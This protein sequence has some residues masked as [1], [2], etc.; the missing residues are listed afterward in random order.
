MS[1]TEIR[2]A[3]F[4]RCSRSALLAGTALRAAALVVLATPAVAQL[5]PAAHPTGG[6]V[7]GG[8]AGISQAGNTTL[9]KQASQAASINWQNFNVGSQA[10]VAFQQPNSGAIALNRVVGPDP[11]EIAGHITANGQVV[12]VNQSGVIFDQ[13]S[14]VDTAGLVVSAS[15]IIDKNFMAGHMVFDQA[16]HP[17]ARVVNN[18]TITIRQAGLAALVAP[19][20]SNAGLIQAKLGRVILAG[21]STYTLDL[22]GD[23]LLAINVTDQVTS[24]SLGGRIVPALVTNMGTIL[25]DGGTVMLTAQAAD[26]LIRT[27]VSAGG[28]IAAQS[29]GTARG[30]ILAQGIG[31]SVEID[32][33]V[34]ASGLAAGT[35]GGQIE[36]NS[37]GAVNIGGGSAIDASGNAGGGLIAIGATAAR[38]A[39]G[40]HVHG[41]LTAS[42]VSVAKGARLAADATHLGDGGRITLLSTGLTSAGGA[43]SVLGGAF[44]G[45]GGAAE[46]SGAAVGLAGLVDARA[47]RGRTG[48]L[49]IDP[50]S[51]LIADASPTPPNLGGNTF[52]SVA[53]LTT[54]LA[55]ANVTMTATGDIDFLYNHGTTNHLVAGTNAL[56]LTA[57]QGVNIDNG[58]QITG[59]GAVTLIAQ[60]G[61]VTFGTTLGQGFGLGVNSGAL[62]A[63]QEATVNLKAST[64]VALG[65]ATI[66]GSTSVS[67]SGST[68]VAGT[69]PIT[70]PLLST[71]A[72][73]GISLTGLTGT[74]TT[75]GSIS[76]ASGNI[77]IDSDQALT[78][79]N[80]TAT[81]GNV[82]LSA[83]SL[84]LG[85][86]IAAL[87]L[88]TPTVSLT[89][90]TGDISGPSGVVRA[91]TLT[92]NAPTGGANIDLSGNNIV[93]TVTTLAA[94]G[95]LRLVDTTALVVSGH[96]SGAQV[97]LSAPSI[98]VT[99]L[100]GTISATS[101]VA[102]QA[103]ALSLPG[104]VTTPV[105]GAVALD[106]LTPG[107]LHVG[108][109]SSLLNAASLADIATGTLAFG[110]ADALTASGNATDVAVSGALGLTG[111]ETSLGLFASTGGTVSAGGIITAGTLYG[112]G[113]GFL[114]TGANVI[115]TLGNIAAG[116]LTVKDAQALRVSGTVT[117]TTTAAI[118]STALLTVGGSVSGSATAL[119]GTDLSITGTAN[120]STSL[121]LTAITGT[122]NETGALVSGLL[123]GSAGG[124]A[125]LAGTNTID[126]LAGFTANGFS[127]ADARDLTVKGS[128]DG[129]GSVGI[130][131]GAHSLTIAA[132]GSVTGGVATLSASDIA[133]A[134]TIVAAT[135]L[136]LTASTGSLTETGGLTTGTVSGSA[137]GTAAL[138]GTNTFTT[139]AA[140]TASGL[141]LKDTGPLQVTGSVNGTAAVSIVD[142]GTL[143]LANAGSI[144]GSDTTLRGSNLALGGTV[145]APG[146]L[147]LTATS[148]TISAAGSLSAGTLT[149]SANGAADF[150]GTN[151]ITDLGIFTAAGFTFAQ[152]GDL[153][154]TGAVAGGATTSIASRALSID[155]TG[156][157]GGSTTSLTATSISIA[158]TVS[159]SNSL[160]LTATGGTISETGA[161]QAGLLTGS[162]TGSAAL[163]GT[164]TIT[165]LGG[166]TAAGFALADTGS[167]HV[168]GSVDGT[169]SVSIVDTGLLTIDAAGSVTGSATTLTGGTLAVTGSVIAATS[170]DL[171]STAAG[172]TAPGSLS[173]GTLSGSAAT[174]A[175]LQGTNSV[176]HLGRFGASTGFTFAQAGAVDVTGTVTGGSAAKITSLGDLTIE[177]VVDAGATTLGG[178]N[179]T[180]AATGSLTGTNSLTLTSAG[181]IAAAGA[182]TT[183]LLT[184]SATGSA[185]FTGTNSITGLGGFTADGINLL[186]AAN[187]HVTGSMNGSS[188]IAITDAGTLTIGGSIEGST[189]T[190]T[191]A[192]L[193]IP[194]TIAAASALTLAS[195]TGSIGETG[196]LASPTLTVTA[197]GAANL[198]GTNTVGTLAAS[199]ATGAFTLDD[200]QALTVVGAVSAGTT[201]IPARLLLSAPTLTVLNTGSL[202]AT[203]GTIALRADQL[204]LAGPVSTGPAGAVA[205]DTLA[206]GA[207]LSIGGVNPAEFDTGVLALGSLDG[208]T[209]AGQV[210]T[211]L[212]DAPLALAGHASA[213]TLFTTATG[214]ITQSAAITVGTLSGAAGTVTLTDPGNAIQSLGDFTAAGGLTYSQ[215]DA[216]LVAGNVGGGPA[217]SIASGDTLTVQ[218]SV[219]S[220]STTLSGANL[221]IT[222]TATG[223]TNLVLIA[224]IGTITETG[225][226]NTPLLTGT[227][228]GS[229][230][231]LGTTNAGTNSNLVTSLGSF[232]SAGFTFADQPDLS[233]VGA[234]DGGPATRIADSGTLTI[235]A[236]Q[237]LS[238]A[239]TTLD[240]GAISIAGT[241]SAPSSLFLSSVGTIAETG[242]IAT[243]SLSGTATGAVS[244]TGLNTI[245]S[246]TNFGAPDFALADTLVLSVTGTLTV[247]GT[248]ALASTGN[249]LADTATLTAGTLAGLAGG[250]AQFSGANSIDTI[251]SFTA[252]SFT[253]AQTGSLTLGGPLAVTGLAIVTSDALLSV[254]GSVTAASAVLEGGS[255]DIP[256]VVIGTNSIF[257]AANAA[258]G[259]ITEAGS[260]VTDQLSGSAPGAATLNGSNSIGTLLAFNANGFVLT[261]TPAMQ[262]AGSVDG[263]S[264][265]SITDTG[266]LTLASGGS[267]TGSVTNLSGSG[268]TLDGTVT[269]PTSLSLTA[270]AGGIGQTGT[271]TAGSLT[272]TSTGAAGFTGADTVTTLGS[273]T[274][275]GFTFI[276]DAALLVAGPI[277][278]GTLAAITS[279]FG[280][281]DVT[282]TV[283]ATDTSLSGANLAIDATST[284]T[285]SSTLTLTATNAAGTITAAGTLA[286]ALLTGNAAGSAVLSGP[287]T[288]TGLGGFT[289]GGFTLNDATDLQVT[290]AVQ[291]TSSVIIIDA[292]ATLTVAASGSIAGDT[293]S[294]SAQ[295]ITSTGTLSAPTSLS[296]TAT[297]GSISSTGSLTTGLLTGSASGSASVTGAVAVTDLADFTASGFTLAQVGQ[298]AVS[299][300]V[301][302]GPTAAI[303]SVDTLTVNGAVTAAATVLTGADL[304]VPGSATGS[305]SL[306]LMAT[307]GTIV[308]TGALTTALL[309][310]SAAGSASL[311]GSNIISNLIDFTASGLTLQ[312]AV[313]LT[314]IG[315]VNGAG[316]ISIADTG[317]LGVATTG[318]ITGNATSLSAASIGIDG[319]LT[320]SSALTLSSGGA[321]TEGGSIS[322][323]LLTGSAAGAVS[324]T[325][326]LTAYSTNHIADLGSFT[327]QGLTIHDL[328]DFG[329]GLIGGS[330][331]G[332]PFLV[333]STTGLLTIAGSPTAQATSLTGS[334]ISITGTA[335][336]SDTLTLTATNGSIDETGQIET[337]LLTG[338]ATGSAALAGTSVGGTSSNIVTGLG[339]FTSAGFGLDTA[340]DLSV[341]GAVN[342]HAAVTIVDGGTLTITGGTL[343]AASSVAG[344]ASNLVAKAIAIDGSILASATLT[345]TA[346]TG[347]I[348]EPA[349]ANAGSITTALLTGSAAGS[350][351]LLGVNA[352]G[353]LGSFS[354]NPLLFRDTGDLTIAGTLTSPGTIALD[355]TGTLTVGPTGVI[356]ATNIALTGSNLAIA[357][358][359]GA[360]SGVTVTANNGTISEAGALTAGTL[361][362]SAT[363]AASL[364]GHGT[365]LANSNSI[366]TLSGF[367]SAS[368]LLNDSPG[369]SVAGPVQAATAAITD[370]GDLTIP[371]TITAPTALT[372]VSTI[373]RIG[374]TGGITTTLL[375]GSA[376]TSASFFGA[377]S[378]TDLG[379]FGAQDFS[380][381]QAGALHVTGAVQAGTLAVITSGALLSI[382]GSVAAG[383]T[384]LAGGTLAIPGTAT[385]S[386]T[387]ALSAGSGGLSETG[388]LNAGLLTG[389]SVAAATLSGTNS[390]TKLG[391]FTAA[392]FVFQDTAP[393]S[394]G[395]AVNGGATVAIG[396]TQSLDVAG[397]GS[398]L[399]TSTSLS[400]TSIGIAG[401]ITAATSLS[402][403]ASAGPIDETG[404]IATALLTGSATG[405]ASFAGTDTVSH[406]G[407]FTAQGLSFTEA[408]DLI[409]TGPVTGG[410]LATVSAGTVSIPGTI[411][412]G[413]ISLAATAGAI[414]EAGSLNA[415]L[416]TGSA[417]G[418][419]SLLGSNTIGTLGGFS[420]AGF[421]L[422]DTPDLLVTGLVDGHASAA[423]TDA[424]TLT[425]AGTVAGTTTALTGAALA[426]NGT[427]SAP[428]SLTLTAVSGG[429]SAPGA[430]DTGSLSGTAAGAA[431]FTGT[432]AIG[433]L[434]SFGAQGFFLAD[435]TDLNVGGPLT[436]RRSAKLIIGG[437]LFVTGSITALATDLVATNIDILASGSVAGSD[438]LTLTASRGTINELG[439]LNTAVL[440]G[441]AVGSAA[442]VGSNSITSVLAFNSAGFTL[443][444][445]PDLQITGAIDGG[446]AVS[447]TDAGTLGILAAGSIT[448]S[449][450]ALNAAAMTEAGQILAGTLTGT[451]T[452]TAS[453]VGANSITT[454]GSFSAQGL[455]LDNAAP[456]DVTGAVTGGPFAILT[457]TG[458]LT[459][460][461][462]ITANAVDLTAPAIAVPGTV[463]G[464]H[465]LTLTALAGTIS[466]T[467]H[468]TTG[469][470]TGAAS[471][472]ASLTG[473]NSIATLGDFTAAGFTLAD[474]PDLAVT[475]TV[476]G[477][478][479]V[480][481]TD[482]GALS[483]GASGSLI[484]ST[485][486]LHA[487]AI[488]ESGAIAAGTLTGA[489]TGDAALTG[490]N[491]IAT[492]ADFTAA[493][494]SLADLQALDIAGQVTAGTLATITDTDALSLTG[495]I[496]AP[497][498]SLTGTAIDMPGTATAATA[499]SL[500]ATAGG[501]TE[502]G[503]IATALLTGNSTGATSLAGSNAISTLGSFT[504]SAFTLDD[505]SKLTVAGPL[506]G[507]ASVS[508]TG[509][510]TLD[511]AGSI[512]GSATTLAATSVDV[513]GTIDAAASL[514]LTATTGTIGETGRITTGLFTGSSAG[515][516][517]LTGTNAIGTLSNFTAAAFTLNDAEA[518][519]VAGVVDG[520]PTVTIAANGKLTVPGSI[521]GTLVS[522]TATAIDESGSLAAPGTLSLVATAGGISTT[523]AI[524][525]GLLTGN[526]TGS[527][528]FTGADQIGTLGD[529]SAAGF[530]LLNTPDLTVAGV[531][532]GGS[533]VAITDTGALSVTGGIAA[534]NA[535]LSADGIAISGIVTT[536]GTLALVSGAGIE[537]TGSL[538]VGLLTGSAANSTSLLGNGNSIAA[539]GDF[540]TA[541]LVLSNATKLEVTGTVQAGAS[542]LLL[543]NG[544]LSVPGSLSTGAGTLTATDITIA[545]SVTGT[546]SLSMTADPGS[547]ASTGQVI[548]PLLTVSA[549]SGG[550]S[551]TGANQIAELD[552]AVARGNISLADGVALSIANTLTSLAGNIAIAA[553]DITLSGTATSPGNILFGSAG[554]ITLAGGTLDAP[555]ILLGSTQ[556]VLGQ[557]AVPLLV[558]WDGGTILTGSTIA[559]NQTKPSFPKTDGSATGIFVRTDAFKQT[560][561]TL[562]NPKGGAATVFI[563]LDKKAGT[564]AFSPSQGNGLIGSTTQLFLNLNAG[565]IATGQVVVAG[566]SIDYIPP[567]APQ[568]TNLGGTIGGL[569]GQSASGRAYI[570]PVP[571]SNYRFNAC[572]IGSVNCVLLS[573]VIVPIFNPAGDVTID[574]PHRKRQDDDLVIPNVGEED[575]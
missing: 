102:L 397:T 362:G 515:S 249:I 450:V 109:G 445:T 190:L 52:L 286:S 220:A 554:T 126:A 205:L 508:I 432:N 544:A 14:Q 72:G 549:A 24:V 472:V 162:A 103:D 253:F 525:A 474:T 507:G 524:N 211:I 69:G 466:E 144:A 385:G 308:E 7:V 557:A 73:T 509:A 282:G 188:A 487:A 555:T 11:S 575:F 230:S 233:V 197:S 179:I 45:N 78:T 70:T 485:T 53:T 465:T 348:N 75:L 436:G 528:S 148:G 406:L 546:T 434:G 517:S 543:I 239:V 271:L 252:N 419:A 415:T 475:G 400:A 158:G 104:T 263:A 352:I 363:G 43:L 207:T 81:L 353:T 463:T 437:A 564:V 560:S 293:T 33:A 106:L 232:T 491:H 108:G 265:V 31:G 498:I 84:S 62:T 453:L 440:T 240:A 573:P 63:L 464:S 48:S 140:F 394:V 569:G 5:A 531:L 22:Y 306:T 16:P 121:T 133:L 134:G 80:V 410:T 365:G 311:T 299:G 93:G 29:K 217:V 15:G 367:S 424:G 226:L 199:S 522:L 85:G 283:A 44:G 288:V 501:I 54:E 370:G 541:G 497:T 469:V 390:V 26:G 533:T 228:A 117:G 326:T 319:A 384:S 302:G 565:G 242:S 368:L 433:N 30:R 324:L 213:L 542:A 13:G 322:T 174:S 470:L 451:A 187:L 100:T 300:T 119:K 310:G 145:T 492:L 473:G 6:T 27:L 2:F 194:G 417:T 39:G 123:S 172:I 452:G 404:S 141:A 489:A 344:S 315:Q 468:L 337:A 341:S 8:Q 298:L 234:V 377:N 280:L 339:S 183:A 482:T 277:S 157:V 210:T 267:V 423:I 536:P 294:L 521:A 89:A 289:A 476:N 483:V 358:G 98:T 481:I 128:V 357:G 278:G 256:G 502:A 237:T 235:A 438:S 505:A 245:T 458:L 347:S 38:A 137:A 435:G 309:T 504:A 382:D 428:A 396:D 426:L 530:T 266:A 166:F 442:L 182:V 444:D 295:A 351:S 96:A 122:I 510:N 56:S 332:G 388:H 336:G 204:T 94:G 290:G 403:T 567:A 430:I 195:T 66:A 219:A 10:T 378:V 409:V 28:T 303:T 168:T 407:S 551:L 193:S 387:L 523:G 422:L 529:F 61:A 17:G 391:S 272:G 460:D 375:S 456:L 152:T 393:L 131:T 244:L 535:T 373:G 532:N 223:T 257:V 547:I 208:I 356:A 413:T 264:S 333:L 246:L 395:G 250:A 167:L 222:G 366:A 107:T 225:T 224:T 556:T 331:N 334:A 130:A 329:V 241:V 25:A 317:R 275:G 425:V 345:L 76:S 495:T 455:T 147:S 499:L 301:A 258:G 185:A 236:G 64:G 92:A 20:V 574:T 545:G 91:G 447:I 171:T 201:A 291:G 175:V 506:Q 82:T 526:T 386:A 51:L 488:T 18:G 200:T 380:F 218:G 441:N 379:G 139:L 431:S 327:A 269:A 518:L 411:T 292:P 71:V 214:T 439:A 566:L 23:G 446:S 243:A 514:T 369:L 312:D 335:T 571:D 36:A 1:G 354:A 550:I 97:S 511:V 132:T 40:P 74:A 87:A 486:A 55:A 494:L 138:T 467:G 184:G 270:G 154:V 101:L 135:S 471:G 95:N 479:L 462:S 279:H 273:F 401:S 181:T 287:N 178:T 173:T 32:G 548:T 490:S 398:I 127:L 570:I 19:Q 500:S 364:S 527:A 281:L 512:T 176:T 457:T 57:A 4:A 60:G 83:A 328:G 520:G 262:I 155:S 212:I 79:G 349:G 248:L 359:V 572:A 143:T 477:R 129:T 346:T 254:T 41:T 412:A 261:D 399:G 318:T 189:T 340:P 284:V 255:L 478:S 37:T 285:G 259:T 58:F 3:G 221:N 454:L 88:A 443:R 67:L 325:S 153:H 316:S 260:L 484:G 314:V 49:L 161:V 216:L 192:A 296:L 105:T 372:L 563:T 50:T 215:S 177:G 149:G 118:T 360:I 206:N 503:R 414:D 342:G 371:G 561:S 136:S 247:P 77:V 151:T 111:V 350:A 229:A 186:D 553:P 59:T 323:G 164:N 46:V 21:A 113:G 227:A 449:A 516:T 355:T 552:G 115:D 537:E 304:A 448:G 562:V 125:N 321:I 9:I 120:G 429:I 392:G 461:G 534:T 34:S 209:A 42:A 402:L 170:L 418:S 416:L 90:T 165:T 142:T 268:L 116:T 114:L 538:Q 338:S 320:A 427:I 124:T 480:A 47:A 238:G 160:T 513:F 539:L 150:T 251:G 180:L 276:Q 156:S 408:G 297:A 558:E 540:T 274:A 361:T 383:T 420:A 389:S 110:S 496:V 559:S 305:Q 159:G 459:V 376:A 405:S 86:T 374:E 112:A 191:A 381:G 231:L 519:S 35:Q 307:T 68:T 330:P 196:A 493:N 146:L 568:L 198:A 99:A 169:S 202:T 163:T 313:P 203:G 421:T 343:S 65:T 12:I